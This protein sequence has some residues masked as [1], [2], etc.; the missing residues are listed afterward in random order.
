MKYNSNWLIEEIRKGKKLKYIFFTDEPA[1]ENAE[2]TPGC[3]SQRYIAGFKVNGVLYK[4]AEHW[5]M[6]EKAKLSGD[7]KMQEA[8][9][10]SATAAE[11][12]ELEVTGVN[13][14]LWMDKRLSLA[15]TGN[16]H[17]FSQN[18]ELKNYL[19]G[20]AN[21][22]IVEASADRVW[23]IGMAA[24]NPNAENPEKWAGLNLLGFALMEVREMLRKENIPGAGRM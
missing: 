20:T 16:Y 24:D 19:L 8:I 1:T 22:I 11:A 7:F 10:N 5:I 18:R 21:R 23:G 14:K 15:I 3:F 2:I 4:T 9:I 17:K 12:K 6:S 13:P